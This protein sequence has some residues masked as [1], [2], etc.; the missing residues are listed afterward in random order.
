MNTNEMMGGSYFSLRLVKGYTFY[1]LAEFNENNTI[2]P[3]NL[4]NKIIL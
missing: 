4:F 2:F 1:I 3:N